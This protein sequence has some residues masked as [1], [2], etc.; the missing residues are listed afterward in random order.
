MRD[1]FADQEVTTDMLDHLR[2]AGP[3]TLI[4]AGLNQN[5]IETT[6]A[7]MLAPGNRANVILYGHGDLAGDL[8]HYDGDL[9]E[10]A[11]AL[12]EQTWDCLDSWAHR[13]LRTG[14]LIRALRDDMRLHGMNLNRRPVYERT[15]S[16]LTT[17][18]DTYTFRDR[19][20]IT[21][22]TC[23][24]QYTSTRGRALLTMF[25]HGQPVGAWP[26][27]LTRT[28]VPDPVREAPMRARAHLDLRP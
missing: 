2:H 13:S 10:I 3:G 20:R 16:S 1:R 8:D 12:T 27:P 11:H 22:T 7:Q 17:V 24:V 4:T 14:T 28:G 23:A 25:D 15:Q 19:P 6:R 21:F 5:V 26:V 9:A 18:T